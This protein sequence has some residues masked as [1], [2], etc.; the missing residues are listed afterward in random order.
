MAPVPEGSV[1]GCADSWGSRDDRLT[2]TPVGPPGSV[3]PDCFAPLTALLPLEPDL[4]H[5][6]RKRP[7][8]AHHRRHR[9]SV[10]AED[11]EEAAV[12]C[13]AQALTLGEAVNSA[14]RGDQAFSGSQ[15]RMNDGFG[16][17]DLAGV[18]P[19]AQALI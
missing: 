19:D 7:H 12:D 9:L 17:E 14:E 11:V 10:G 15:S 4:L 18:D 1:L 16:A 6:R 5:S 13:K 3:A 2:S 8:P